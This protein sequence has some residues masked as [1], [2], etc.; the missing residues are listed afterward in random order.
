MRDTQREAETQAEVEAGSM[1]WEPEVGF[2]LG[3]PGSRPGPKTGTKP[4]N[5]PGI[6][7]F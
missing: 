4:L 7:F 1:H 2:H 5:H 6:P 3:S